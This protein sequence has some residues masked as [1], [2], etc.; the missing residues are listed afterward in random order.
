MPGHK[1]F[2]GYVLRPVY[3]LGVKGLPESADHFLF[4]QYGTARFKFEETRV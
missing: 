2:I 1:Y 3:N 4:N